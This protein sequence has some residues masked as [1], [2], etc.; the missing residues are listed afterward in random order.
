MGNLLCGR[1]IF[2]FALLQPLEPIPV[3]RFRGFTYRVPPLSD[4]SFTHIYP[5]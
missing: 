3:K 4:L 1:W 2:L 5:R